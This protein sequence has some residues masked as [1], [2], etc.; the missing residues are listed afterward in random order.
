MR[1][2]VKIIA[3]QKKLG[4]LHF[5]RQ[6]QVVD[7]NTIAKQL[8]VSTAPAPH[9]SVMDILP[10]LVGVE[11]RIA[12]IIDEQEG[13]Y[14]L[15][16]LNRHD[17]QGEL[18]YINLLMLPCTDSDQAMILIEDVTQDG[19]ILQ[20]A[21]Q[22]RYDLY[23]YRTSIEHR[24][25]QIGSSILGRSAAIER[26]IDTI[27]KLSHIASAT[28]LLM[29][30]TG[31]GKNLTARMIHESSMT[32]EA[33]FVEINCAAL[34]EQLIEAELFGYEKGAFTH[35][36]AAKPGLFEAAQ[37]GTIFLDE[38]AEL[39]LGMQA[40][41]LS[42]IESKSLRRLGSTRSR[43]VD[44]R[45]IAATNRDLQAE[46]AA[47]AFREDLLYRL[48]VVS[49]TLPP[50][51]E[52][53]DDIVLIGQRFVDLFNVQFNKKV[54]GFSP[55]GRRALLAHSWPGNVRELSNCIERAMIF[56]NGNEIDRQDLII[57][58]PTTD[59][60]TAEASRWTVP[61]TGI[62]L[63]AVEQSLIL[64]ALEQ[65]RGNKS[66]AARLLGLTRHTL[67]YRME[68]HGIE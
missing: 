67:R 13:F 68:K 42:V 56:I 3:E 31:T 64:S 51:R 40:K 21:N 36:V 41:L 54:R 33:P 66:E 43:Q 37:G 57:S 34:P 17:E 30:E 8:L 35:A 62:E 10:E 26:I 20:A 29:G 6:L 48:N 28:V 24:K 63:E 50:L 25:K 53:G 16:H 58:F 55:E 47:K 45:I 11:D 22:Q 52:L 49:I 2:P 44:V 18:R 4:V 19:R 1:D 38:I 9:V 60:G 61:P 15:D 65:A 39:P 32:T 14:R 46:V 27:Q 12:R 5:D 23:L 59:S 7:I